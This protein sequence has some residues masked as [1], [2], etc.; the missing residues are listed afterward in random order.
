VTDLRMN[1]GRLLMYEWIR[2]QSESESH[3]DWQSASLSFLMSS[4]VRGSWPDINSFLTV[5]VLS[6][7]G[8][9]SDERSGLSFVSHSQW[10]LSIVNSKNI[11]NFT[12]FN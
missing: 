7:W 3:C 5:T 2:S 4:P 6:I 11:Y 10:F 12:E 9:L 1:Y 8:A